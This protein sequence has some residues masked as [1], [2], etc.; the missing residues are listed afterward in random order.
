LLQGK[1]RY[2]QTLLG[3]D[4]A[5]AKSLVSYGDDDL[6]LFGLTWRD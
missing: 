5:Q 3:Q 4:E 1:I 6:F 2:K